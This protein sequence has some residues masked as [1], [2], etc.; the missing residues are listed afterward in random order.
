MRMWLTKV[1]ALLLSSKVGTQSLLSDP[2]SSVLC[3]PP[4][5]E[6][7]MSQYNATNHKVTKGHVNVLFEKRFMH[8]PGCHSFAPRLYTYSVRSIKQIKK[9]KIESHSSKLEHDL[10]NQLYLLSFRWTAFLALR[11]V[12]QPH[13]NTPQHMFSHPY[14]FWI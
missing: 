3:F 14:R 1:I 5:A 8:S 4:T 7:T 13:I 10:S 9:Q 6:K 11:L 12:Q 2:K